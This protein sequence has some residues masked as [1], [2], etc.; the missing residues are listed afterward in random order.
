[1]KILSGLMKPD[2]GKFYIERKNSDNQ[3]IAR[4]TIG[5]CPQE[6]CIWPDLTL[7]EQMTMVATLSGMRSDLAHSRVTELLQALD[8]TSKANVLASTLSGG[9][10]RRLNL[11]L[12]LVH[13]PELCI[14]DEPL[15]GV[16]LP[17]R[18]LIREYIISV[19][20]GKKQTIILSTH[21][22]EEAL[23][24]NGMIVL[25][26]KGKLIVFNSP[27]EVYQSVGSNSLEHLFSEQ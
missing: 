24:F 25:F 7:R 1:M 26:K 13:N 16:D 19:S 23:L 2:K 17:G 20:S 21:I 22:I 18:K 4:H 8:L 11:G 5:Y 12:A 3:T 27:D 15:D 6:I 10:Q 9:M 14:L